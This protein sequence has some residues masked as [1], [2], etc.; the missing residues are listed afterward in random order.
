MTQMV[1]YFKGSHCLTLK[2]SMVRSLKAALG[3]AHG[4][5]TYPRAY[6]RFLALK[7]PFWNSMQCNVVICSAFSEQELILDNIYCIF[8]TGKIVSPKSSERISFILH[9]FCK[10]V[11]PNTYIYNPRG[12]PRSVCF[13]PPTFPPFCGPPTQHRRPSNTAR[14]RP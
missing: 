10:V 4:R 7:S 3:P 2:A 13:Y 5:A 1:N 8:T 11:F 12:F 9:E 14:P 6:V